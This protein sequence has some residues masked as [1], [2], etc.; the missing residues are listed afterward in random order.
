MVAC[1]CF[2]HFASMTDPRWTLA[3]T[4]CILHCH[5]KTGSFKSPWLPLLVCIAP[6]SILLL[7]AVL[8]TPCLLASCPGSYP[9]PPNLTFDEGMRL[10]FL[11]CIAP[12][13]ALPSMVV[14]LTPFFVSHPG[15]SPSSPILALVEGLELPLFV[16][17]VSFV[18]QSVVI[19]VSLVLDWLLLAASL[20][21]PKL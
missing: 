10:T 20:L 17:I 18:S 16:C 13:P 3:S 7:T 2:G 6:V 19:L 21:S 4:C 12:V 1:P 11:V 8:L 9:L 5:A 14:L 15:F